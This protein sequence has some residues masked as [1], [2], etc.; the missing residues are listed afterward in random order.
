MTEPD[1]DHGMTAIGRWRRAGSPTWMFLAVGLLALASFPGLTAE[2]DTCSA[3]DKL[4]PSVGEYTDNFGISVSVDGDTG[5]V[6]VPGDGTAGYP[7]GAIYFVR[8]ISGLWLLMEAL[9]N[10]ARSTFSCGPAVDGRSRQC[11][12][13]TTPPRWKSLEEAFPCRSILWSLA[14]TGTRTKAT[15]PEP[16]I[17]SRGTVADGARRRSSLQA[18]QH[19]RTGSAGASPCP[20]TRWL[21]VRRLPPAQDP[22]P[23]STGAEEPGPRRTPC[24]RV[25]RRQGAGS[26]GLSRWTKTCSRSEHLPPTRRIFSRRVG[27]AGGNRTGSLLATVPVTGGLVSPLLSQ[28]TPY[29]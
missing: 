20:V 17:S 19:P 23:C 6:G 13:R 25:T 2:T 16:P 22:S 1:N 28:V 11:S 8:R 10:S 14:P 12:S 15:K 26:G 3:E 24:L 29:S 5:V 27:G 4:T 18:A 7:T 21:S 9:S